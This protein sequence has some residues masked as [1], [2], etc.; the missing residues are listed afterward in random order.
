MLS[1]IF[2]FLVD[3]PVIDS[4]HFCSDTSSLWRLIGV[5]INIVKI[6]IPIIII[7]LGMLDLGKAVMAGEEKEISAAQKMLIKRLI[8]GVVIFFVVT[9]VQTVFN[10]IGNS[11]EGDAAICWNCVTRPNGSDCTNVVR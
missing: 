4:S 9:I 10:L 5:V 7:I 6:V 2:S 8:Y 1:N 11:Y 3:Q